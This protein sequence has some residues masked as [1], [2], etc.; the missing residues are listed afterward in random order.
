MKFDWTVH[1]H[2]RIAAIRSP[3]LKK[4]ALVYRNIKRVRPRPVQKM[5][6]RIDPYRRLVDDEYKRA[7]ELAV[8]YSRHSGV[9]G[10][11][12]EFGTHGITA[13]YIA[14]LLSH[15]RDNKTRLHMFDS[16]EGFPEA[17]AVEDKTALHVSTGAWGK[18]HA[19]SPISAKVIRR[20]LE[21]RLQSDQVRIYAG[22]Y[23]ETLID[24][25]EGTLFGFLLMDCCLF[26]SHYQALSHLLKNR[27]VLDGA[28]IMF[29]DFGANKSSPDF[30][31]RQ[32]W[33]KVVNEYSI[34]YSQAGNYCWGGQK[35]V[36]HSYEDSGS[37]GYTE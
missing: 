28:I 15:Y 35:F 7:V 2:S 13:G 30:G 9:L 10:E 6:R 25:P 36:I 19:Q 21:R 24:I 3:V 37:T 27:M 11:I 8:L 29:S 18:G 33:E 34:K 31:A 26:I 23:S 17:E 12:A 5:R 4:M 1:P 22:W 16:F 14:D 20:K 32:A